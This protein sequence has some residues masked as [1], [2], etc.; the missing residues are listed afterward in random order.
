LEGIS[1]ETLDVL[2]LPPWRQGDLVL[3]D[4][5]AAGYR[6]HDQTV[7]GSELVLKVMGDG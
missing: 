6:P 7:P 5:P 1:G 4:L 3:L 2:T